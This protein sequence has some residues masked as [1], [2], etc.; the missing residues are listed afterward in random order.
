[1]P[2]TRVA[3]GQQAARGNQQAAQPDPAH[4]RF[5]IQ[6]Y[7]PVAPTERLAQRDI[8]VAEE[9]G[10]DRVVELARAERDDLRH[11]SVPIGITVRGI[12]P[13]VLRRE[14]ESGR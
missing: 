6:T 8:D 14:P 2:V 4:Q 3:R 10:V 13:D 12:I 1:M 11:A 7:T 9:A 5:V